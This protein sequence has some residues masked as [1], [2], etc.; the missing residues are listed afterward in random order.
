M[1]TRPSHYVSRA[2]LLVR[3]NAPPLLIATLAGLLV[4]GFPVAGAEPLPITRLAQIS[5]QVS[6]LQKASQYYTGLMGFEE[7]FQVK[8][9]QGRPGSV[10][11]KVNDDQFLEFAPG[12]KEGEFQL[13]RVSFLVPDIQQARQALK[14]RTLAPGEIHTEAD[15]NPHCAIKDPDGT[16]L[17][18]VQY[19]PDSLQVKARGK[20]LGAHRAAVHLQH[21]GLA[22]SGETASIAY[23]RDKLGF[24]ETSRGGQ[25][26][27]ETRWIIMMMPGTY[28][29]FVE[30][31][32]YQGDPAARRRHLCFA[33]PD[34][35]KAHKL[36]L[37]HGLPPQ[38]KP[39]LGKTG[40]WFLNL[41]DPNGIRVEFM[42]VK[43]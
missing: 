16:T 6:D 22:T 31:M 15:G 36:L 32:V 19:L 14:D 30:L 34:I 11:F 26:P 4:P 23:Y 33:V 40:Q 28:G 24:W 39:F 2:A 3:R 1:K 37:D 27:G 13:T 29:D 43:E 12:A 9:A 38:P 25:A 42:E 20:A 8:D 5:F 17:D 21:A 35:Q 18:F 10:Y 7:T 41:R